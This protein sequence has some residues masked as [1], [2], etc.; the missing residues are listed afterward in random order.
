MWIKTKA[1]KICTKCRAKI[2]A[3]LKEKSTEIDSITS[4]KSFNDYFD[5]KSNERT[6]FCKH[7]EWKRTGDEN[8]TCKKSTSKFSF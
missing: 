5:L 1:C 2:K 8:P 6:E 7:K 4:K 3:V